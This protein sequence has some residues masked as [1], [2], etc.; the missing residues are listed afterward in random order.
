MPA[1]PC[2]ASLFAARKLSRLTYG[3]MSRSP[4]S[5]LDGIYPISGAD[6]GLLL[7]RAGRR[8]SDAAYRTVAEAGRRPGALGP[9][10]PLDPAG[11]PDSASS[12]TLSPTASPVSAPCRLPFGPIQRY[13]HGS[14]A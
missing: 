10:S 14:S 13:T 2:E 11:A 1:P 12:P 4:N 5:K 9:A 3:Q 7:R 8:G 6:A